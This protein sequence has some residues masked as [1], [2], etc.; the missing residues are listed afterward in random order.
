VGGDAGEPREDA[1][2]PREAAGEP[3]ED[4]GEPREDAGEPSV[5]PRETGEAGCRVA[6][7]LHDGQNILY[8]GPI[9]GERGGLEKNPRR[10]IGAPLAEKDFVEYLN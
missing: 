5:A 6:V 2:E 7:D 9:A 3:R 8:D 4:A 10:V 1:G